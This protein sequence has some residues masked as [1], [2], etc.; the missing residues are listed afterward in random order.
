M[1]KIIVLILI[2]AF[3]M[4]SFGSMVIASRGPALN[5]GDCIP[6]GSGFD[7]PLG[8]GSGRG[9]AP[10]SGDCIPDGPEWP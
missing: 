2:V 3:L 10:G 1:K 5:S 8:D 9:P 7:G 4:F 6:D